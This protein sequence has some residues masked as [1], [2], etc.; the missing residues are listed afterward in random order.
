MEPVKTVVLGEPPSVLASLIADRKRL[1]LDTHDEVWQ[2][3]Y[4][5]APAAS[6]EH[7]RVGAG[8]A[9]F[10]VSLA[11][12]AGLEVSLEFNLGTA[13]NF[14]VPDLGLHRGRPIGVWIASAA[15]VVEVR[16]PD[17]ETF[18]KFG[19]Y[20]ANGVEEILVVDPQ[21]QAVAWFRRGDHDFRECPTS[22]VLPGVE[23]LADLLQW[24]T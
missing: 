12:S 19:F 21:R 5:M 11:A 13:D 4:H 20:H 10:L 16:S 7:A 1:G 6:F 22:R 8:L 14:R 24:P 3:E 15:I 9:A 17:D 23:Q 2:G 18:A